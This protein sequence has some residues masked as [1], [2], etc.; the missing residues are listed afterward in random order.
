MY[1]YTTI[2]TVELYG[3]E[4]EVPTRHRVF[5]LRDGGF[6]FDVHGE[7]MPIHPQVRGGMV[8]VLTV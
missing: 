1:V 6:R 3:D 5:S 4:C 7:G 2:I 8:C